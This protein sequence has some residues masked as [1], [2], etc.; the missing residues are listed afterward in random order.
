MYTPISDRPCDSRFSAR[1]FK[2]SKY[3]L[4]VVRFCS[5]TPVLPLPEP[6]GNSGYTARSCSAVVVALFKLV[7]GSNPASGFVTVHVSEVISV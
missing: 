7:P 2:L 4:P 3:E 1:R 6:T 5:I